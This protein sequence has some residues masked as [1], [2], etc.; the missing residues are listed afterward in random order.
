MIFLYLDIK[1]RASGQNKPKAW[2]EWKRALVSIVEDEAA[3]AG[4]KPFP[5][6]D[7]SGFNPLSMELVP[8][9]NDKKTKMK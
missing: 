9:T 8:H 5:L 4:V 1:K 2:E 7:F 6:W 3:K